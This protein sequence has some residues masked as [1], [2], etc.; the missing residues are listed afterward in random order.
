MVVK[1]RKFLRSL[2]DPVIFVTFLAPLT[3]QLA[4]LVLRDRMSQPDVKEQVPAF[5][6]ML[7]DPKVY[8]P[9]DFSVQLYTAILGWVFL[10]FKLVPTFIEVIKANG[11]TLDKTD[12]REMAQAI[13]CVVVTIGGIFFFLFG[14]YWRVSVLQLYVKDSI[15]YG[16]NFPPMGSPIT[17]V[18]GII[19]LAGFV[20]LWLRRKK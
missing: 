17:W 7:T 13:M 5:Y 2:V 20:L 8:A 15:V 19:V 18:R 6:N 12:K 9:I 3:I 14:I 1:M 16:L 10:C 4:F 11:D